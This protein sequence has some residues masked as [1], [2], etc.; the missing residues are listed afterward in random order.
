MYTP[1]YF[2]KMM[3]VD[4]QPYH[5]RV[6]T[7]FRRAVREDDDVLTFLWYGDKLLN[8]SYDGKYQYINEVL[9]NERSRMYRTFI[10]DGEIPK[11]KEEDHAYAAEIVSSYLLINRWAANKQVYTF[12]AE[13]EL[14]LT[15]TEEV[16]LPVRILDRLPH[17]TFYLEFAKDGIFASHFHGAFIHV[18]KKDHGYLVYV[19]RVKEDGKAMHGTVALVPDVDDGIFYFSKE[20]VRAENNCERNADWQEFGLFLMNALL[21]LCANNAQ[22][23]ESQ[24]TKATYRPQKTVKNKFSEVRKWECG[25]RYGAAVRQHTTERQARADGAVMSRAM[26]K[27]PRKAMVAHMRRA[28]WHH[29]WTG[30]RGGERTLIL[31]WIPPT[32]VHGQESGVAVIHKVEG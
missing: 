4:D 12:D 10:G 16:K 11:D 5:N 8:P 24:T 26:E 25:Y 2:A 1:L 20:D 23:Q 7:M 17:Q 15:D 29:Y 14:S 13:L 6:L 32:F 30:K 22:I 3:N 9:I 18:V 27:T 19:M 21:Y 28:H 31:H